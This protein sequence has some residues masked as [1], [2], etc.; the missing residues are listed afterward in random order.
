MS[1]NPGTPGGGYGTFV[2]TAVA[3]PSV[4]TLLGIATWMQQIIGNND[5]SILPILYSFINQA[6]KDWE[7]EFADHIALQKSQQ[8]TLS[9]PDPTTGYSQDTCY[10]FTDTAPD[11]R[12]ERMIRMVVPLNL[13][14]PLG[15]ME[16]IQFRSK[17][18]D[19]GL[20]VPGLPMYW[21]W[22][23]EDPTGFHIWPL[24]TVSGYVI[25]FDYI[26]YAPEL[27]NPTDTPFFDREFHK[28]LAW[29]ALFYYYSSESVAMPERGAQW[30]ALFEGEKRRYKKDMQRRQLQSIRIPYSSGVNEGRRGS[31][32]PFFSR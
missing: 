23:P 18:L 1:T 7:M 16:Y 6:Q 4:T 20:W 14:H 26:A 15:F 22:A 11:F 28:A 12:K 31:Y 30:N 19:Q 3:A 5:S 8:L 32:P 29:Q 24:P 17:I 13:A 25:Q 10:H 21:Y 27:I 9:G 2:S